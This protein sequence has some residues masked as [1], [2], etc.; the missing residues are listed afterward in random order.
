MPFEGKI[1]GSTRGGKIKFVPINEKDTIRIQHVV[2][3]SKGGP[4]GVAFADMT[5]LPDKE[6][7]VLEYDSGGKKTI[8]GKAVTEMKLAYCPDPNN[9]NISA[10]VIYVS[11]NNPSQK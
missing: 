2:Y 6:S 5:I 4:R 3:D 11:P 8:T 1:L 7:V 10:E 9:I